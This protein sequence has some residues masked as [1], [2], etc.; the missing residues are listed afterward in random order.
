VEVSPDG[1]SLAF[2]SA[3]QQENLYVSGSDGTNARRLTNDPARDRGPAWAP[4]GSRIAFYSDRSGNY[5]IWTIRPD[6]TGLTQLTATP[7][8]NRSGILWSPDASRLL[9][10]QR[11]GLAW[12]TYVIDAGKPAQ[13][14]EELPE[15]GAADEYFAATSWSPDGEKLAG[16]RSYTDRVEPGGIFVYSFASRTFQMI[17]DRA[18]GARWLNDNRRLIYPDS[19][20]NTIFLVDTG[21]PK[22]VEIYS[23]APRSLGAIR[24]S[25]DNESL[26]FALSSAESHIW[27]ID[28]P[29]G[30]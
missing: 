28:I 21:S 6:G 14:L 25:P 11:S 23:V 26:Y 2:Y 22:P 1:Q 8:T 27:T 20:T 18:A 10:V 19:T 29:P 17:V 16:N 24:L 12:E 15:I 4:D 30:S 3:L 9:Y 7:Q 5:E 13:V